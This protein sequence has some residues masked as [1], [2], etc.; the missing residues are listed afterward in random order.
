MCVF[1]WAIL[2]FSSVGVGYVA[3][4]IVVLMLMFRSLDGVVL[5]LPEKRCV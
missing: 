5:L 1:V 3:V 4:F 2:S